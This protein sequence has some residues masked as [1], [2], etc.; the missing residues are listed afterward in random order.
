MLKH[1][2]ARAPT[3]SGK[4]YVG[5]GGWNF[6]PWRGLFYPRDLPQARELA[7]MSRELNS[8]EINSTFYSLQKPATFQ[9]W[10]DETPEHFMFAVKA[11]RF[12]V[13]RRDLTTAAD[14]IANFLNSGLL[15]LG[16]K[17]GPIN[18]QLAPYKK[19]A[20][21]EIDAFLPLLPKEYGG[22]MLRHAIEVRHASFATP[23]FV[24]LARRHEVAIVLAGDAEYPQIAN[25]T[26]AF[27]YL[28]IMGTVDAQ[29]CGY[30]PAAL[31]R[32]AQRAKALAQGKAPTGLDRIPEK[33]PPEAGA[34]E[35]FLY[36]I[37]GAK[38]RNPAAAS[39]LLKKLA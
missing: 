2:A 34:R 5:T 15:H 8:I 28:R 11:P 29:K 26:A 3:G 33:S 23:Q 31:T 9:R 7:Y 17:L 21:A 10:H 6:A 24:Q 30:A 27:S 4:I 25:V 37:S 36:V 39:A 18:W 14:G 22:R 12:V 19:F 16:D 13:G 1:M 38:H 35:V 20:A 32:W